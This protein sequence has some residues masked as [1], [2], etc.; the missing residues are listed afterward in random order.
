MI[1]LKEMSEYRRRN[2]EQI[3]DLL[4]RT[5]KDMHKQN[6]LLD[7]NSFN[8]HYRME[9]LS[10]IGFVR[11]LE[12]IIISL[13]ICERHH[14]MLLNEQE[15]FTRRQQDIIMLRSKNDL[16]DIS[17]LTSFNSNYI[18]QNPVRTI[19]EINQNNIELE[20]IFQEINQQIN[21]LLLNIFLMAY[22]TPWNNNRISLLILRHQNYNLWTNILKQHELKTEII[23]LQ[24]SLDTFCN[25]L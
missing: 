23:N 21:D 5:W 4:D 8:H 11:D 2:L 3:M 9:Q 25:S 12:N 14:R 18:D 19:N 10:N 13:W 15:I 24:Q 17:F 22:L 7:D 16:I 1:R 6:Y 20:R